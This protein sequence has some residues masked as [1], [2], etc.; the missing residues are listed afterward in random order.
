[1]E[2]CS[3]DGIHSNSKNTSTSD[4]IEF[5]VNK[6]PTMDGIFNY[7]IPYP[8]LDG[9]NNITDD[10]VEL[11]WNPST[12]NKDMTVRRYRI[13]YRVETTPGNFGN[14]S[15]AFIDCVDNTTKIVVSMHDMAINENTNIE[16]Q[17]QPGDDLEWNWGIWY[18]SVV[19][20]HNTPPRLDGI[21][22]SDQDNDYVFKDFVTFDL[23]TIID[24]QDY[25]IMQE[26]N[27]WLI[28]M[29]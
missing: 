14:W 2:C 25:L 1:M 23:P 21:I 22:T 6:V 10:K 16:Y 7:K 3:V 15:N 26:I 4:I 28:V 18:G 5:S 29:L 8:T 12:D 17:I 13:R 27:S 20:M 11:S 24:P 9:L 19:V